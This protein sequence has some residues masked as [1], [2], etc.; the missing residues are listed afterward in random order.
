MGA[1]DNPCFI[2]YSIIEP[3][4]KSG[5]LPHGVPFPIAEPDGSASGDGL[6]QKAFGEQEKGCEPRG[7]FGEP[8]ERR[9]RCTA[10]RILI[11]RTDR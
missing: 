1:A 8:R 6:V 10:L 4:P 5:H 11:S 2:Y 9:W 7:H 3:N